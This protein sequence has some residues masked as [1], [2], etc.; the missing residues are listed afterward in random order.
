MIFTIY[1]AEKEKMKTVIRVSS[2]L[3]ML[4]DLLDKFQKN[5]Y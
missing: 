4:G 5:I 2:K 1:E 3:R